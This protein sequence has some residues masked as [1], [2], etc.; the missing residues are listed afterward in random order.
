MEWRQGNFS[1]VCL[2]L[3]EAFW[4]INFL[5]RKKKS[6]KHTG[7]AKGWLWLVPGHAGKVRNILLATTRFLTISPPPPPNHHGNHFHGANETLG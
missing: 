4:N 1:R 6:V 5:S 2:S 7:R 3:P